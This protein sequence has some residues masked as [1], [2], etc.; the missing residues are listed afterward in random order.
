MRILVDTD[1]SINT[2]FL[3]YHK[4]VISQCPSMVVEYLEC[5]DG[6]EYDIVQLRATLALK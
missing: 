2:G 5:D 1:A 3:D 6:T 4:W